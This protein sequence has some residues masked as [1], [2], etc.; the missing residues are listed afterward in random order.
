MWNLPL[1][2]PVAS[3]FAG[4][5]D[6]L[7][8]VLIGLTVFFTTLVGALIAFLGFRYRRGSKVDRS[9]PVDTSHLLEGLWSVIPLVLALGVFAWGAKLY[10][11]A[12]N[13]PK[14][15]KEIYVI[16]KQWMWHAQH[17]NG[18]R[19][20]NELH[21]PVGEP[22]RLNMISQDVIHSFY[23]PAFRIKRDV[24]PGITTSIWFT[25][26]KPGRYYL[27]CAEYCG[28][29]HSEMTGWV[30][31][32]EK[33]DFG[34]WYASNG[35]L[36]PASVSA[37]SAA[38]ANASG[39]QTMAAAGKE[40]YER[41]ACGSCHDPG[42]MNRGPS[43]QGLYGSPVRL[44]NGRTVR[45]DLDYLRKSILY[46]DEKIVERYQQIMPSYRDQ[47]TEDQV[48][49]L[50]VYIRTL[51]G[52]ETQ[53]TMEG[54]GGAKGRQPAD[55]STRTGNTPGGASMTTGDPQPGPTGSPSATT[56]DDSTPG[57][58]MK[59]G[60]PA[61]TPASGTNAGRRESG[62]GAMTGNER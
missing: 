10:V 24:F 42:G 54:A 17:V 61:Q 15:A 19:E 5:Y 56:E 4:E 39:P 7:F 50:V 26:T 21:V 12:Y 3:E 36:T 9:G 11:H 45:A 31:V 35:T 49:Q 14:N 8:F 53:T 33:A 2:P 59:R 28:T 38:Q 41:L 47:L 18:I 57:S 48:N 55:A 16:G 6:T 29:Q 40:T 43:L 13:V 27:F 1:R 30:T 62:G 37:P 23:I 34:K 51:G 52:A 20:N 58:G 25:P 60:A 32:M 44:S 22:I 46:S